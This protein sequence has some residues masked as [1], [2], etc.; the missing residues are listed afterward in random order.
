MKTKTKQGP[1]RFPLSLLYYGNSHYIERIADLEAVLKKKPRQ[2]QIDMMGE[3]EIPADWALLIRSILL[4][5]SPKTQ[6]ITNARSSLQN[7]SMLVWLLGDR[8]Q[9]R[10]D[11]RIFLRRAEV[12]EDERANKVWK[13]GDLRRSRE[14]PE[15]DPDEADYAK[16]LRLINEFISVKELVGRIIEVPV[17]RQFGLVDSERFDD[18]LATLL[19]RQKGSV[20]NSAADSKQKPVRVKSA[21][22][23][24]EQSGK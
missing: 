23:Q 21:T 20:A 13:E 7:S 24:P 11:A 12:P 9:I 17:L 16:V 4:E 1:L 19:S 18:L 15:L 14:E 22:S 3:G 2:L 6:L 8:R 10:E 5:R